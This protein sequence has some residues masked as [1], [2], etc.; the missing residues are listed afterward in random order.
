MGRYH[1][2]VRCDAP[3]AT[4]AVCIG[5]RQVETTARTRRL[6][7]KMRKLKMTTKGQMEAFLQ[8]LQTYCDD[9]MLEMSSVAG[10]CT[11]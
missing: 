3:S 2:D 1:V 8:L 6:V 4:A 5:G 9:S 11:K 10:V 7:Q